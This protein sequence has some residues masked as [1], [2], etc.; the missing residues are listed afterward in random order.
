[1]KKETAKTVHL[2]RSS[3]VTNSAG[4]M[5]GRDGAM[6][7]GDKFWGAPRFEVGVSCLSWRKPSELC[8]TL[9]VEYF[10]RQT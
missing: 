8:S 10:H 1:M 2:V 4:V 9:E 7:Q 3:E 5:G 6:A